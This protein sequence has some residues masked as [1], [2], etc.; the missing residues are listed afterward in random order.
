MNRL[1]FDA[2]ALIKITKGG[3]LERL[4]QECIITEEVYEE[5]VIEG[6]NGYMKMRT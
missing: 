4:W 5:V 1:A 2:D 6:K 3:I